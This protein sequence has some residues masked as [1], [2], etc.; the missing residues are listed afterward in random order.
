MLRRVL[1]YAR[2]EKKLGYA[3]LCKELTAWRS[4]QETLW[5]AESPVHP[6]QQALKDLERAYTN[7]FAKR[8]AFP[9]FRKKGLH[10]RFRYPDPKQFKLDQPNSRT[11]VPKLGWIR[12]RNSRETAIGRVI[13]YT[14]QLFSYELCPQLT[15]H[16]IQ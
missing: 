12:Y 9:Q 14:G 4:D 13:A 15:H 11:F 8:A 2:G 1:P 6:L 7:F 16:R 3:G 5:L 10:D